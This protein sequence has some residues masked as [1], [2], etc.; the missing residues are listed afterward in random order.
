MLALVLAGE[1]VYFLPF[2][3]ARVFRPT[4][5]DVFGFSNFELGRAFSVYGVVAML[6]YLPGGPLA[7]RFDTRKMLVVA[8][9]STAAGGLLFAQIPSLQTLTL[10]F[11][12]WGL[13]TI[14]LFWSP[15]MRATRMWGG[16]SNQGRAFGLLDAGRGLVA[17]LLGWGTVQLLGNLLPAD[18]SLATLAERTE[19]FRQVILV[20]TGATALAAL[21]VWLFVPSTEQTDRVA[22]EASAATRFSWHEAG[23]VLKIKA[24][25]PQALIIVCAYIG[26]KCI[27]DFSLYARD[28]FGMDEVEAAS[29]GTL[30]LAMRPVAALCAGL[31]GDRIGCSKMLKFSF[32]ALAAISLMIGMGTLQ[33]T[34]VTFFLVSVVGATAAI[35]SLRSVYYAIFEEAQ[36]P[37]LYTGTA[38]GLVSLIGYTPDIFMGPLIGF[39][40]D[41]SPG[42]TGHEH[43]FLVLAAASVTGFIA[44]LVFQR[45]TGAHVP[46][47][48]QVTSEH[49]STA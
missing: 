17:A 35:Y 6:S 5:L 3:I 34:M 23:R 37:A 10:L 4:L 38:V 39:L 46:P 27:G 43:V 28:G 49:D 41:R 47:Q 25:W 11:G 48:S 30:A 19:A 22:R 2:L 26:Y 29:V 36:I 7:D 1:A 45:L 42:A 24:L 13:S 40:T 33:P 16:R 8:L 14:L 32:M 20:F 12:F 44:T 21:V 9:L 31:F 15:L 18:P